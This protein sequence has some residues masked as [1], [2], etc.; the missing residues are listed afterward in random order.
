MAGQL[1]SALGLC[2][3]AGMDSLPT[4]DDIL[5]AAERIAPYAVRTPL[6]EHPELGERA[7]GRVFLKLE[8]FQR[9]GSFKFRGACNRILLIPEADRGKGA[10]RIPESPQLKTGWR[11]A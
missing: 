6:V 5:A 7:G 9:T 4:P 8:I 2:L 10:Q 3:T 11:A 1:E